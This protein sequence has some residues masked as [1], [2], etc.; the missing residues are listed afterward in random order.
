MSKDS[1][2]KNAKQVASPSSQNNSPAYRFEQHQSVVYSKHSNVQPTKLD[3]QS[4][5][6]DNRFTG[7]NM[8]KSQVIPESDRSYNLSQS[9]FYSGG[10]NSNSGFA[11]NQYSTVRSSKVV[12]PMKESTMSYARAVYKI[13]PNLSQD[14]IRQIAENF[15]KLYGT[16]SEITTNGVKNIHRSAY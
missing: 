13:T 16:S 2:F 14:R 11:N 3:F 1:F 6:F 7:I 12:D 9:G 15:L 8:I 10:Y 5:N 4:S